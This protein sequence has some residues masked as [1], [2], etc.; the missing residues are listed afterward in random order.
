LSFIL[1][2]ILMYNLCFVYNIIGGLFIISG[3]YLVTWAR[4]R[5]KLAGTAASYVV[6]CASES[7]EGSSHVMKSGNMASVPLISLV[8]LWNVPHES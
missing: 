6:R 8:R 4:H 1:I 2:L 7:H 5:E 3:L